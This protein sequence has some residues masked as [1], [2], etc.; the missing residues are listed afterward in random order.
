[1]QF[2]CVMCSK[3]FER[4]RGRGRKPRFCSADCK[5]EH[6]RIRSWENRRNGKS[7]EQIKG[8]KFR[9]E[10]DVCEKHSRPLVRWGSRWK[11]PDC[12]N[13][14]R[15][16]K[17]RV[18]GCWREKERYRMME[19]RRT[20]NFRLWQL[21]NWRLKT[22]G[23]S[24]DDTVS[25]L[26]KQDCKCGICDTGI[27]EHSCHVD[28]CHE[29]NVVRGLLCRRCNLRLGNTLDWNGWE[30]W[31]K[32]ASDYKQNPPYSPVKVAETPISPQFSTS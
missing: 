13:V 24:S 29:T 6:Q 9:R 16:V 12:E 17:W 25:L 15:R 3:Q 8:R 2:D 19:A 14:R 32:A 18:D 5:K 11:C 7:K 28:H 31:V 20:D 26:S 4:D 10:G 21:R 30:S 27:D 1:M 23:L 22:Y